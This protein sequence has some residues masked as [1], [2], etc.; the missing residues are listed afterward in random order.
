[1]AHE[2]EIIEGVANM[3][4]VGQ[5]PWHG[6]GQSLEAGATP[7][8]MMV[9]AGADWSVEKVDLRYMV[10]GDTFQSKQQALIRTTDGKELTT[11]G[12]NWNPVQNQQAF[13]FFQQFVDQGDMEMS[14]AGVLKDGQI[15]WAMAKVNDGFTIKT[16]KGD[17]RVES[18]LLFTNPHMFGKS[19]NV[20]FTPV[21]VVCANTLSIALGGDNNVAYSQG[22]RTVF[23]K[24]AALKTLGIAKKKLDNYA[25]AANFLANKRYTEE[26]VVNYFDVIFPASAAA[27]KKNRHSTKFNQAMGFMHNQ[28]G[29]ELGEGT[30]WQLANTVS[31]MADHEDGNKPDTRLESAWLGSGAKRKT[32]AIEVAVEM[33]NA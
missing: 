32:K 7:T 22:H 10:N 30:F 28:P 5:V 25:E 24:D 8:E 15:V 29:A 4:Y 18:N 17:D 21:R 2:I 6:L 20:R 13:D 31:Y 26:D 19:L 9:A 1:M 16:D 33:A 3:A 23:D 27:K 14:T 12:K 11:V